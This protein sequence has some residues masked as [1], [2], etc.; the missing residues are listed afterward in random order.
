MNRR[1]D[2]EKYLELVDKIRKAD[3]GYFADNGYY[4]RIPGRDRRRFPG[5]TGC[6]KK[7]KLR[8][9]IYIYLFQDEAELRQPAWKIRCRKM[10]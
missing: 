7:S 5:D 8:Y 3:S 1:Y 2:K 4:G 10:W 6:G 9:C